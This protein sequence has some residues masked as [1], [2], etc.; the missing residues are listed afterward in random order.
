ML[1]NAAD[2]V[3]SERSSLLDVVRERAELL[4]GGMLG[5][6]S[7]CRSEKVLEESESPSSSSAS[8]WAFPKSE[9]SRSRCSSMNCLGAESLENRC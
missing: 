1:D 7:L 9:G 4:A 2:A 6:S 5:G 8:P 3:V